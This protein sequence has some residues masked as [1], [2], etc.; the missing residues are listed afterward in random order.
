MIDENNFPP[1]MTPLSAPSYPPPLGNRE[2]Q[3]AINDTFN[4]LRQ[5]EP[6]D[7]GLLKKH[8]NT[9]LDIQLE[10]ARREQPR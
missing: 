7:Y 5:P 2:L 10:R 1:P 8:L 3:Q 4:M 9:L 6:N